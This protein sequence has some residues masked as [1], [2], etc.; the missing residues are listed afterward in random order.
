MKV[1]ASSKLMAV[2]VT[3]EPS[4]SAG[5]PEV[6]FDTGEAWRNRRYDVTPDGNRFLLVEP[7]EA[8]GVESLTL[9][10]NWTSEL[11]R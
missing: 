5:I 2:E 6:L 9:V 8:P 1:M 11:E 7:V 4:F 10:Q 3:L